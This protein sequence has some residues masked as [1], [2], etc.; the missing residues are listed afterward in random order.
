MFGYKYARSV[1]SSDLRVDAMHSATD[2]LDASAMA[3]T[4]RTGLGALLCRVKYCDG[5]AHAQFESGTR[6]LPALLKIWKDKVREKGRARGWVRT[7]TAWDMDAANRLYER[8]AEA[9]LAFWIDSRCVA[10]GGARVDHNR[11]TCE[12]CNG[13][14]QAEIVSG[15]FE[16]EIILDL[17]SELEDL[18]RSHAANA[19]SH[20][21]KRD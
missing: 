21:R 10:C 20:L 3:D 4:S 11:R 7:N 17:V 8:V 5:T 12:C 13:T 14:G 6:N 16:R 19:A 15:R 1:N 2:A 18:T 9:S